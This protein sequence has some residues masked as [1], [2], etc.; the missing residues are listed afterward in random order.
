MSA[1]VYT[2]T[3]WECGVSST[4]EPLAEFCLTKLCV[5]ALNSVN[6]TVS[7]YRSQD[8]HS[9]PPTPLTLNLWTKGLKGD[10]R[11]TT[12]GRADGLIAEDR[13]VSGHPPKELPSTRLLDSV[14][15]RIPPNPLHCAIDT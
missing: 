15:L 8:F 14:I 13:L 12:N 7:V 1:A 5:E 2:V 3:V 4:N 9:V 6:S 10:F 11:T